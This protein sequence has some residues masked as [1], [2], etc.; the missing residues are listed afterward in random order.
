MNLPSHAE[1]VIVGGGI[2]GCSTAYH[3]ALMGKKDV[4]LLEQGTL[5]CGTTWHAAGLVG[6]MRPNRNMTR[7]SKYGIELYSKLEA[8]TGLAT[9]WKQCG[10]VNVAKTPERMQ[11]LRKQASMARS[12]GVD[13]EIIGPQRAGELYPILRTDDLQ[14]A[15][16]IPGDGKANPADLTMSLAKGARNRGVKMQENIEVTGVLTESGKITGVRTAQGDVKCDVIV[17]CAGQWARQFGRLAGVNVPLYSAEHFYIV[18]DTIPGVHPML[19]VMRDPDGFIYYKEEVGGLVM[20]GFEPVA[21][22]W[23]MDPIPSNFQFQLLDEDW[24]QFEILM[25]NAIHRTPCLETAPIKMLLNG[26]ESFTPDGN[27]ILGEAPELRNYFVC[28]GFN[29]AGIANSGGAGRLIAEWIVG[30]E[31]QSDLWDVDIRRF[32]A[33]TA[34][35]RAL[36]QRTGE[37]LGLHYAMRWPRQELETARPL[38]TSPLYDQ[39]AAKGA[40]FGSRNGWERANYF[41]P[42]HAAPAVPGLGRPGW[43]DWVI[44]EQCATREAVALYDQ[45]SF[46]KLLLQG[47]DALAVLQRLCANEIDIPVDKM[48]Y[49]ALLNERGGFES[50]LT[51][52]RLAAERFLI[53]TGSAQTT[54]DMDWIGRHIEFAEHAT[55]TDV[56]AQFCVLSL[57]GPWARDLLARVSPDDLSAESLKFSWTREIDVGFARVRAARMSY[58]G[59]PGFELYVP[60]EMARHVYL[61]LMEAGADLGLKDAGYYALDAL[62]IEAGRRAWGAELGPDET[63]FEAGLT[64]AVKLD[65]PTDFIG[66]QALLEK[67]QQPLNKKLVTVVLDSA[68]VYAWGGE[69]IVVDGEIVG[70]LTSAGW[71]PKANACVGLGYIRGPAAQQAHHGGAAHIELWGERIAAQLWDQW[72]PKAVK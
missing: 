11:V 19:P 45:T 54:R 33:F 35:R 26:P 12:F 16:W 58:V 27:F 6:Q 13:V 61:T 51:V 68:A 21:K 23:K 50:D 18:T 44:E 17:N 46:S 49:T 72:P 7:M 39:L 64:Y 9:G 57:M 66:R 65:K 22:P 37:T 52:I 53:I 63:P 47:R 5:T 34:N 30:G 67:Q 3:L 43:L 32:G 15:I 10:S 42:S 38:R 20:G 36:S 59:G 56:S 62:R 31:A 70:E 55:L 25:N 2:A 41:R 40:V 71:S 8:E 14:G 28:A 29:S 48:V 69:G 24:D 1:I 4:L 60:V